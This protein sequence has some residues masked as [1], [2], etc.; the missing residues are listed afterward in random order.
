MK[1]TS[2][3]LGLLVVATVVASCSGKK[4]T[5]PEP[6][7]GQDGATSIGT[8]AGAPANMTGGAAGR[9]PTTGTNTPA[10]PPVMCGGMACPVPLQT[11]YNLVAGLA[12]SFGLPLPAG[13]AGL[14]PQAC[15]TSDKMCGLQVTGQGCVP[16]PASDAHCPDV[17]V[18][19]ATIPG[20]CIEAQGICGANGAQSGMGCVD[21]SAAFGPLLGVAAPASCGPGR[22]A[23]MMH[24][25]AGSHDAG[26]HDAGHP[27]DDAGHEDAGR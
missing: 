8:D 22:D 4:H 5:I 19:S 17:T 21:L 12:Q 7:S 20:C 23:G 13:G 18:L 26:P 14:L 1:Q 24:P 9:S 6:D 25:D 11:E 10:P 27:N 16:R 3:C 15:C 2:L